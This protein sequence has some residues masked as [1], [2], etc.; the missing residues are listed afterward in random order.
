MDFRTLATDY[1]P[2]GLAIGVAYALG[3][4]LISKGYRLRID[5][6]PHSRRR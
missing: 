4:L 5:F 1:G 3:R 6:G 2:W